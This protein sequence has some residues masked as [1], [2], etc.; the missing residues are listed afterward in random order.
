MELI[1]LNI[2]SLLI[3][4]WVNTFVLIKVAPILDTKLKPRL[5]GYQD[6]VGAYIPLGTTKWSISELSMVRDFNTV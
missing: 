5:G 1:V 4:S 2:E 6:M 3:A